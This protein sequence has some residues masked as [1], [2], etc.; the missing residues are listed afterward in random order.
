MCRFH[1]TALSDSLILLSPNLRGPF[2]RLPDHAIPTER[3]QSSANSK[4]GFPNCRKA[5]LSA[6]APFVAYKS[7]ASHGGLAS[8]KGR[9]KNCIMPW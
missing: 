7:S 4:N 2:I 9:K 3:P 8:P 5:T 1:H 6:H